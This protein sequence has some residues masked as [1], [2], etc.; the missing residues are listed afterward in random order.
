[1]HKVENAIKRGGSAALRCAQCGDTVDC[2]LGES[3]MEDKEGSDIK[4]C[5]LKVAA[6]EAEVEVVAAKVKDRSSASTPMFASAGGKGL[7]CL[8][9][10]RQVRRQV[11]ITKQA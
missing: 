6:A 9:P 2:G 7:F 4:I 8:W 3:V 5:A 10:A 11:F 1:M